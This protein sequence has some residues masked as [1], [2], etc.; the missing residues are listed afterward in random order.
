MEI[1]STST[2]TGDISAPNIYTKTQVDSR[3]TGKARSSDITSAIAGKQ[4]SLIFRNPAQLHPPVQGFP[5][6]GGGIIVPAIACVSPLNWTYYG[7]DYIVIGLAVDLSQKED[8]STT[9]TKTEVNTALAATQKTQT[10]IDPMNLELPV[11]SYPLLVGS[12]VIP[13][14]SVQLPLT[15]TRNENNYLTIGVS[16][17]IF[18]QPT[19]SV[20]TLTA[21]SDVSAGSITPT[22]GNISSTSGNIQ[23]R[24]GSVGGKMDHFNIY[25]FLG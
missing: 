21:T 9:Y 15:L 11:A 16:T 24:N 13:G 12:N 22:S 5:L 1:T 6:L 4:N 2:F 14:L 10:V 7:S 25:L 23:T 8:T 17:T 18:N 3:L 19:L 20:T